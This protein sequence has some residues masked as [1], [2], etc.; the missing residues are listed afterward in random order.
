MGTAAIYLRSNKH[1]DDAIARQ[2][3]ACRAWAADLDLD[4]VAEFVDNGHGHDRPACAGL[5]HTLRRG[6][7]L[8][9][10]IAYAP[11]R[12]GRQVE[13]TAVLYEAAASASLDLTTITGGVATNRSHRQRRLRWPRPWRRAIAAIGRHVARYGSRR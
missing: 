12:F 8:D 4:V 6:T 5:V 9:A 3:Q 7:T 11:D 1:D 10:V 2:R 13:D